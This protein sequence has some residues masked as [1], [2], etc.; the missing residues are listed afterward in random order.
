[1]DDIPTVLIEDLYVVIY[2][3]LITFLEY[4]LLEFKFVQRIS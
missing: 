3:L 1:M 2:F 4:N